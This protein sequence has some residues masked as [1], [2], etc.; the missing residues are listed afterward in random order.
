LLSSLIVPIVILHATSA[1]FPRLKD[2]S[3]PTSKAVFGGDNDGANVREGTQIADEKL[4]KGATRFAAWVQILRQSDCVRRTCCV[5]AATIKEAS[6]VRSEVVSV[7]P[8]V[9]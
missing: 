1:A 3:V 8:G 9:A 7:F 4:T 2:K 6:L 5:V